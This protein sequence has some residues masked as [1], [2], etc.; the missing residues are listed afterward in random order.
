MS[1]KLD[2]LASRRNTIIVLSLETEP[3]TLLRLFLLGW[4]RARGRWC[5]LLVA[6][7]L[8]SCCSTTARLARVVNVVPCNVEEDGLDGHGLY[9]R[10][11]GHNVV[12]VDGA[13]RVLAERLGQGQRAGLAGRSATS[14]WL[15][16]LNVDQCTSPLE[17]GLQQGL[18][19]GDVVGRDVDAAQRRVLCLAAARRL[20]RTT[21]GGLG[22]DRGRGIRLVVGVL[23]EG[24]GVG[25]MAGQRVRAG[26]GERLE[27][28]KVLGG[29]VELLGQLHVGGDTGQL[30]DGLEAL[31]RAV[32]EDKLL[33][34]ARQQATRGFGARHG[35]L[36][37]GLSCDD[38]GR[39]HDGAVVRTRQDTVAADAVADHLVVGGGARNVQEL[40]IGVALGNALVAQ[41]V[42]GGLGG[43]DGVLA[44]GQHVVVG[45]RLVLGGHAGAA[46]H[47]LRLEACLGQVQRGPRRGNGGVLDL[48]L[49]RPPRQRARRGHDA[50]HSPWRS[51]LEALD[52][53]GRGGRLGLQNGRVDLV[54]RGD[55]R[56]RVR[57]GGDALGRQEGL[58]CDD[59]DG[60]GARHL[61]LVGGVPQRRLN[62]LGEQVA[63]DVGAD[64]GVVG[65]AQL[66]GLLLERGGAPEHGGIGTRLQT[67]NVAGAAGIVLQQIRQAGGVLGGLVETRDDVRAGVAGDA[68][69]VGGMGCLHGHGLGESA[70]GREQL[71]SEYTPHVC[72]HLLGRDVVRIVVVFA[73]MPGGHAQLFPDI[74]Q[75]VRQL[76]AVGAVVAVQQGLV[77]GRDHKLCDVHGVVVLFAISSLSSAVFLSPLVT[78][79]RPEQRVRPSA[80]VLGRPQRIERAACRRMVCEGGVAGR[81]S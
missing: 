80:C 47:Q 70:L 39:L 52:A 77:S 53:V 28:D 37:L 74:Q 5:R 25:R 55:E 73:P 72:S 38:G 6:L 4:R 30:L 27:G 45:G 15:L 8:D 75:T 51:R 12:E 41:V 43:V 24:Q 78:I 36:A 40:H 32:V 61:E 66:P 42:D 19:E 17:L 9:P 26:N 31:E 57:R 11:V 3:A 35:R 48:D 46:G 29:R 50:T 23:D 71:E 20:A 81:E 79:A 56:R 18:Q 64:G 44:D 54:D 60:L 16:F 63:E 1:S 67:V 10:R 58:A 65:Q 49:V 14:R 59:G 13:R 76:C 68:F 33:L 21:G 34:E 69:F 62:G 7:G 2:R 22:E